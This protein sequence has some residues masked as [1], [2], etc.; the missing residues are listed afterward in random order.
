MARVIGE[1]PEMLKQAT[2]GQCAA[3]LE[4]TRGEVETITGKDYDGGTSVTEY[5]KCP[6]CAA[7]VVV[8]SY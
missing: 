7:K 6:R 3:R 5:I 4:Y 2:C 8:R 1:A